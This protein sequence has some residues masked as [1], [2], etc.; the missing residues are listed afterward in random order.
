MLPEPAVD[1]Y[2]GSIL[3]NKL[4]GVYVFWCGRGAGHRVSWYLTM[5]WSRPN[6]WLRPVRDC[7]TWIAPRTCSTCIGLRITE[8]PNWVPLLG[9]L[10]DVITQPCNINAIWPFSADPHW[11]WEFWKLKQFSKYSRTTVILQ[12]IYFDYRFIL[13]IRIK[14]TYLIKPVNDAL[15]TYQSE[16]ERWLLLLILKS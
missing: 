14:F 6:T 1:W 15:K 11:F 10:G 8:S 2:S 7:I 5:I 12:N 4:W 13:E 3:L 16:S 9:E